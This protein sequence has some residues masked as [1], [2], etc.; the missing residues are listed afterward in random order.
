MKDNC[1]VMMLYRAKER[2]CRIARKN[3]DDYIKL[4]PG[5]KQRRNRDLMVEIAG[6]DNLYHTMLEEIRNSLE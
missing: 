1:D 6:I 2:A 3:A 5:E 4:N